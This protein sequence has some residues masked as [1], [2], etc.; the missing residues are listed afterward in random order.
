[1]WSLGTVSF[2]SGILVCVTACSHTILTMPLRST[3]ADVDRIQAQLIVPRMAKF[4]Q[5]ELRSKAERVRALALEMADPRDR[6][7]LFE[8]V[9]ELE[10]AAQACEP[11]QTVE[12]ASLP[13]LA[14]TSL[15][16]GWR[17]HDGSGCPLALTARPA[18]EMRGGLVTPAGEARASMWGAQ[19]HWVEGSDD[20]ADIIAYCIEPG[21]AAALR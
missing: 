2:Q 3:E 8:Y 5:I 13:C 18:V 10:A 6:T 17:Q 1:M 21:I 15:S 16:E 9:Q 12:A 11:R 19:W 20:P 14:Q 7:L 4:R